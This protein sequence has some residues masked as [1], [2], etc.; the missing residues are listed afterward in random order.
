VL[1]N[2]KLNIINTWRSKL[3]MYSNWQS[4]LKWIS[5]ILWFIRCISSTETESF[6]IQKS[7]IDLFSEES[8]FFSNIHKD[9]MRLILVTELTHH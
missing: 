2:I 7:D 9:K 6:C 1:F 4:V 8:I 5:T 3:I